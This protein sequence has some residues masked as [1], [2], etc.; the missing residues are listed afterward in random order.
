MKLLRLRSICNIWLLID[1]VGGPVA[2]G[3]VSARIPG[4][5]VPG[6][7]PGRGHRGLPSDGLPSRP[8]GEDIVLAASCHRNQDK[9]RQL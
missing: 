2:S 3:M 5:R 4:E 7:C 9:L 6:S 1:S 8:G